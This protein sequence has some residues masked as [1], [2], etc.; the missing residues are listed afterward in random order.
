MMA[1]WAAVVVCSAPSDELEKACVS[2]VAAPAV[3]VLFDV[4]S[5]AYWLVPTWSAVAVTP[6][7]AWLMPATTEASEPSPTETF[8]A[9]MVPTLNPPEIGGRDRAAVPRVEGDLRRAGS[10]DVV[11]R[12]G[13]AVHLDL[14]IGPVDRR[15][16]RE[17]EGAEG[18]ATGDR[19]GGR[20]ALLRGGDRQQPARS[21]RGVERTPGARG[22]RL[23]QLGRRVGPCGNGDGERAPVDVD[24]ELVVGARRSSYW[25]PAACPPPRWRRPK[26]G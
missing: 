7:S 15:A 18:R 26:P 23:G 2:T 20:A 8:W 17:A 5:S 14:A 11:D 4:T 9:V 21:Y 16:A 13:R 12:G 19:E 10:R 22:D 3:P 25:R 1:F 24:I 6:A